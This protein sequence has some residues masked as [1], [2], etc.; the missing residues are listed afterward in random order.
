MTVKERK[1]FET[2][3]YLITIARR[4]MSNMPY[5]IEKE[6]YFISE[7]V[8]DALKNIGTK[9]ARF[10]VKELEKADLQNKFGGH[11]VKNTKTCT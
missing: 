8:K 10:F 4:L 1:L 2:T 3:N 11:G 5:G 9:E 6:C 7:D